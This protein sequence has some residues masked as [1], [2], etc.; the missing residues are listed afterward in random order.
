MTLAEQAE[1]VK[2]QEIQE[3][4]LEELDKEKEIERAEILKE[5]I[6]NAEREKFKDIR[7]QILENQKS[8]NQD[9]INGNVE[10][11]EIPYRRDYSVP[12]KPQPYGSWQV[13]KKTSGFFFYFNILIHYCTALLKI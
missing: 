12:E 6:A 7:M 1:E 11:E 13:V 9:A 2:E 5:R 10:T 3:K 8:Q 4:F